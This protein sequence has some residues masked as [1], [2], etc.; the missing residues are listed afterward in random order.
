[1]WKP[2]A[3]LNSA[4]WYASQLNPCEAETYSQSKLFL[5]ETQPI[6]SLLGGNL[7]PIKTL[8]ARK[9]SNK[10]YILYDLFQLGT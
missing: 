4:S 1:M 8:L 3:S 6:K 2:T 5:P 9:P 7:Q 10:Q